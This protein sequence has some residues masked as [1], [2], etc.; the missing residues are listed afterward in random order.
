M[1]EIKGQSWGQRKKSDFSKR[2]LTLR[3]HFKNGI[4]GAVF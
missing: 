2:G 1:A 4:I 3:A